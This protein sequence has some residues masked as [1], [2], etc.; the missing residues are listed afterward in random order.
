VHE[1]FAYR[2]RDLVRL[3]A[4]DPP[5]EL[6]IKQRGLALDEAALRRGLPRA[7]DGPRRVVILWRDGPSRRACLAEPIEATGVPG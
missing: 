5:R 7:V 3:L 2:R 1:I 4:Q 6:V